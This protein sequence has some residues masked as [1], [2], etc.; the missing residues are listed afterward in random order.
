M[1][2]LL[3]SD[4]VIHALAGRSRALSVLERLSSRHIGVSMITL[5][6][7]YQQAFEATNPDASL[8]PIVGF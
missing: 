4:W 8:P 3:D 7:V 5:A 2:Y 6:E 1:A